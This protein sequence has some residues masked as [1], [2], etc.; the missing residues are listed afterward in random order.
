MWDIEPV[1]ESFRCWKDSRK[2]RKQ[3]QKHK[4]TADG[5]YPDRMY[6]PECEN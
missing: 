5:S 6:L 1:A 4:R 3:W 2:C